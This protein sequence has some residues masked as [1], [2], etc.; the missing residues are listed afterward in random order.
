M[1]NN[2]LDNQKLVQVTKELKEQFKIHHPTIQFESLDK[3]FHC[4]F[5]PEDVI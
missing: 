4:A 3:N 5:K 2:L 1:K